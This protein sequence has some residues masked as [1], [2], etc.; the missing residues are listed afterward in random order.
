[1]V[2]PART[3]I[4]DEVPAAA[5]CHTF[6]LLHR[7]MTLQRGVSDLMLLCLRLQQAVE[8]NAA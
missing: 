6:I 5:R 7:I 3:Q 1:M 8:F 4:G 2:G